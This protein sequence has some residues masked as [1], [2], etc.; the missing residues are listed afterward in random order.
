MM[1]NVDIVV[2]LQ[3]SALRSILKT[4]E[5]TVRQRCDRPSANQLGV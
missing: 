4:Q 5:A 2:V 3:I 1:N